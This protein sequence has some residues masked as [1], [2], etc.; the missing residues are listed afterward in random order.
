MAGRIA[1]IAD[2][3]Q[4][5]AMDASAQFMRERGMLADTQGGP[6]S[7]QE[8]KDAVLGGPEVAEALVAEA[9]LDCM[10]SELMSLAE[11]D[12][13]ADDAEDVPGGA[14]SGPG[15]EETGAE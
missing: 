2:E 6:E 1:A 14:G 7:R 11:S 4:N 10:R 15:D 13:D 9:A 12:S 3:L 8:I 5:R